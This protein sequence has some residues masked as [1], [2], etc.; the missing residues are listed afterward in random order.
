MHVSIQR[1]A[2]NNGPP[3]RTGIFPCIRVYMGRRVPVLACISEISIALHHNLE[4]TL[5]AF[6]IAFLT[7]KFVRVIAAVPHTGKKHIRE[8]LASAG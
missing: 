4:F 6:T 2:Q 8:K 5:G 7:D 1:C 3:A